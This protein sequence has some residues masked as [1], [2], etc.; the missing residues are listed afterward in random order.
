MYHCENQLKL[1]QNINAFEINV[2]ME[3]ETAKHKA[4]MESH[5]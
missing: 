5:V 2:A 3:Q 1:E 4:K